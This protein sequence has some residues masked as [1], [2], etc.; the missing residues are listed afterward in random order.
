MGGGGRGKIPVEDFVRNKV[1]ERK[2]PAKKSGKKKETSGKE[3]HGKGSSSVKITPGKRGG[4]NEDYRKR[5]R[6]GER[7]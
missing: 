3:E 6:I 4:D 5:K 7:N 2:L 1:E